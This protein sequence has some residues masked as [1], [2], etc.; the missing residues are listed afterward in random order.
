LT[1]KIE[2]VTMIDRFEGAKEVPGDKTP[3]RDDPYLPPD[4]RV[5][6]LRSRIYKDPDSQKANA[7]KKE[8]WQ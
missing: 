5:R 7:Q 3:D 1:D 4:P 6:A 2:I 8:R